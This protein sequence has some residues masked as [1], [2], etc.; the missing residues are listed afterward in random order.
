VRRLLFLAPVAFGLIVVCVLFFG[1]GRDPSLLPSTLIGKPL[2]VFNLAPVAEGQAGLASRDLRGRP[3]LLNAFASWCVSCRTEHPVLLALKA[4]GVP[5]DGLDWKDTPAAGGAYLAREGD[6]YA[7][8]GS[9]PTGRAGIDLGVAAVPETFVVDAAG[10][11]R[12]KHVGP[13]SPDDWNNTLEPL[14][15]RLSV[16]A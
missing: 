4:K 13:I 9:D 5:I 1:L 2:P 11:V 8:V 16:G 6:P 15:A 3:R 10:V 7:R 12:Y 14:M